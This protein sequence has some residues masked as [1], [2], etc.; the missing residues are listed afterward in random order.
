MTKILSFNA[1]LKKRQY[2][3]A[4]VFDSW[5][6]SFEERKHFEKLENQVFSISQ[7]M[8][9]KALRR[10][11]VS[12]NKDENLELIESYIEIYNSYA[13]LVLSSHEENWNQISLK[14]FLNSISEESLSVDTTI[15]EII[16]NNNIK[17]VK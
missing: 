16:R 5:F 2:E 8:R 10:L 9:N 14:K 11:K 4:P 12:D 13:L 6:Q 3:S 7:L 17:L 15:D 1:A